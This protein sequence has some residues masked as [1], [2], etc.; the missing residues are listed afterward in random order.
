MSYDVNV[1]VSDVTL[2]LNSLEI[3]P[4]L[5]NKPTSHTVSLALFMYTCSDSAM[6][7]LSCTCSC[8]LCVIQP[9]KLVRPMFP[10]DTYQQIRQS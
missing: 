2:G 6:P 4:S 5:E 8:D 1:A 7:L 9:T 10:L 3:K